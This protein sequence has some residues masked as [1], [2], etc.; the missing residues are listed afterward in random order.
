MLDNRIKEFLVISHMPKSK[1]QR[2]IER[3]S[4]A[5]ISSFDRLPVYIGEYISV[6]ARWW[7]QGSIHSSQ[8]IW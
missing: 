4:I 2:E 8:F 1:D 5:L 6:L 7:S 3:F